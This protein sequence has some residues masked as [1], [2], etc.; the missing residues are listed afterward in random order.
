MKIFT[1]LL[2]TLALTLVGLGGAK[3]A[4]PGILIKEVDFSTKSVYDM[5]KS[6][7][8][9]LSINAGTL[10]IEN[11]TATNNWEIQYEGATE[12]SLKEHGNYIVRIT[13]KGSEPGGMTC[14]LGT[15]ETNMNTTASFT[16]EMTAVDFVISDFPAAVDNAHV[17]LQSGAF[18]GTINI[19][20]I[21]VFE[22]Y[23]ALY[24][25]PNQYD[26]S[27]N[28][29]DWTTGWSA[30]ATNDEYNNLNITLT[31]NY[32]AKGIRLTDTAL[33]S[34]CNKICVV[35]ESY[36]GGWGQLLIRSNG[37]D[38]GSKGYGTVTAGTPQT[39]TIEYDPAD[40]IDEIVIQC[41]TNNPTIIVSRVYLVEKEVRIPSSLIYSYDYADKTE[42]TFYHDNGWGTRPTVSDGVLT[43]T[44]DE[45][46]GDPSNYMFF[47]ADNISTNENKAYFVRATIKGSVAGSIVCNLGNWSQSNEKTLSFTDEYQEVDVLISGVPTATNS[48]VI[49]KIGK[50]VGTIY[51]K[52]IE[53]YETYVARTITVSNAGFSTFSSD[54][55]FDTFGLVKAYAATFDYGEG[56]INLTPI[57]T[58][59]A[60]VGVIIEAAQGTYN[61]PII[62]NT[63]SMGDITNELLVSDGTVTGNGDIYAL[64]KKNGVVGFYR[65]ADGET[66]PAGKAYLTIS[67]TARDFYALGD[68]TTGIVGNKREP[69]TNN[70]YYDLQGRKVN[71]Q[72][73]KGLYIVNG[74]KVIIK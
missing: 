20:K 39:I 51:L 11:E 30:T 22:A 58:I 46:K 31:D 43:A 74:K 12:L 65:V 6:S 56:K 14:A 44:N 10:Q 55:T 41:G 7:L 53:V 8:V 59:P 63:V 33:L 27:L 34:K 66:V 18:A 5:W 47:V 38:V 16:T 29:A 52:K 45:V 72:L 64:G 32:G 69:I 25:E 61:V 26:I 68:E 54:Y 60:N 13:L 57:S 23:E 17:L 50:Y 24:P 71:G 48:H 73:K 62:Q 42:H 15:W 9:N 40:N 35:I 2:F 67:S 19:S 37:A 1:K 70:C 28:A 36:G 21:Q 49:F 3:A 4:N